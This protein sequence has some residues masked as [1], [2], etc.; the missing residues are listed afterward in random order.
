[1]TLDELNLSNSKNVEFLHFDFTEH[2]VDFRIKL[3][4]DLKYLI[5][6][7]EYFQTRSRTFSNLYFVQTDIRFYHTCLSI[8][9]KNKKTIRRHSEQNAKRYEY[10]SGP[11][12]STQAGAYKN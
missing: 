3:L 4:I 7:N 9:K 10:L 2:I 1:M 6:R 12:E 5:L 8:H 11:P